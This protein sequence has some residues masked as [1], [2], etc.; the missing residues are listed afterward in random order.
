MVRLI[1]D[2]L[3][4]EDVRKLPVGST[5]I[6]HGRDR[7]G[8]HTELE[9]TLLHSGKK[10]VLSWWDPGTGLRITKPIRDLPN[11]F[12]TLKERASD[13]ERG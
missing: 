2:K 13:D 5:V 4:A 3:N 7:R 10:K 11:K 8:Y 1:Q 6:W 9:C 12:F